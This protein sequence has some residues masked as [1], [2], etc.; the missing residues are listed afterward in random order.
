SPPW[1]GS[2]IRSIFIASASSAPRFA[3]TTRSRLLT[4]LGL[5]VLACSSLAAQPQS[6]SQPQ[7]TSMTLDRLTDLARQKAAQPYDAEARKVPDFLNEL[8]YDQY[9]DFRFR[10][11]QAYWHGDNLPF[12]LEFFHPGYLYQKYLDMYEIGNDGAVSLIPFSPDFFEYG[13][14]A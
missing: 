9:R 8:G 10:H 12:E 1:R 2:T 11:E 13:P 6:A 7:P 4:L 3:S 14:Q 5:A